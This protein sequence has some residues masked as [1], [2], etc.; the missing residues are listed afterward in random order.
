[1]L[2]PRGIALLDEREAKGDAPL[3]APGLGDSFLLPKRLVKPPSKPPPELPD[4]GVA[5]LSPPRPKRDVRPLS[6]PPLLPPDGLEGAGCPPLPPRRPPNNPPDFFSSGLAPGDEPPGR[7]PGEAGLLDPPKDE[8]PAGRLPKVEPLPDDALCEPPDEPPKGELLAGRLPDELPKDEL[9]AGRLPKL[10]PLDDPLLDEGG[11]L[12]GRLPKVDPPGELLPDDAGGE[13][14]RFG[15]TEPGRR[16]AKPDPLLGGA[17]D[18][19]P[20]PGKLDV[21]RALG[22]PVNGLTR[23]CDWEA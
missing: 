23:D 5:G 18:T 16:D 1:V 13:A 19:R 10:D 22:L 14:G 8:L 21:G 11:E 7:A 4:F 2:P 3:L 12:A 17:P 15:P 9:L 6:G 20:G